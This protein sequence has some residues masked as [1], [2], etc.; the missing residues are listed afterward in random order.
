M[1]GTW[2]GPGSVA[3]NTSRTSRR[4]SITIGTFPAGQLHYCHTLINKRVGLVYIFSGSELGR[5]QI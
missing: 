4:E 5:K 2:V 3:R 1:T